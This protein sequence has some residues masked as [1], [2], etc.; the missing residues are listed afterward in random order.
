M[1]AAIMVVVV[2]ILVATR[3]RF[4]RNLTSWIPTSA[5]WNTLEFRTGG[6]ARLPGAKICWATVENT[7]DAEILGPPCPELKQFQMRGA[8]S[9]TPFQST[10][11]VDSPDH[12][13]R[14]LPPLYG[15]QAVA[16]I[17]NGEVLCIEYFFNGSAW[18]VFDYEI[19]FEE[20][21][22]ACKITRSPEP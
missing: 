13:W 21:S 15:S 22:H 1:A 2:A 18:R 11:V 20:R 17:E 8:G 4:L 16:V 19:E 5:K 6:G 3:P 12:P 7:S 10:M 14:G 9:A